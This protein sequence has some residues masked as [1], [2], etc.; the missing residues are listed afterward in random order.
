[1]GLIIEATDDTP[2]VK[3]DETG[4][5]LIEGRSLPENVALF[6]KPIL[7]W[8]EEYVKIPAQKTNV[9][10]FFTY[11]NSSS[12]KC[13]NDILYKLI[14]IYPKHPMKI[15]WLYEEDDQS[16]YETGLEFQKELGV[17]FD[18]V[19]KPVIEEKKEKL[20]IRSRKNNKTYEVTREYWNLIVRNGRDKD[21]DILR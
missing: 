11:Y 18:I 21:F 14:E 15:E 9:K 8:I 12:F 17:P 19:E 2:L 10:I 5:I 16:I 1:M 20:T 6:Y 13:I 3:L 4:R 7:K